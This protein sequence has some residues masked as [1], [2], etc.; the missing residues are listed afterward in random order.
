MQDITP[1]EAPE[2]NPAE[3]IRKVF[4]VSKT[5][6]EEAAKNIDRSSLFGITPDTYA[7][8]KDQ[9]DPEADA[10]ERTPATLEPATAKHLQEGGE[11]VTALWKEDLDKMNLIEKVMRYEKHQLFDIP[12]K[13]RELNE[14]IGKKFDTEDGVLEETEQQHVEQIRNELKQMNQEAE[15]LEK[16]GTINGVT[17]FATD[18][19]SAGGD[20]IRSYWDNIELFGGSVG[21]GTVIGG[22]IGLLA[23]VP[24]GMLVGMSMGAKVGAAG[25][26]AMVGFV[27][28]FKQT[29][30][31]L[32][33]EL[34]T[35]TDESGKPLNLPHQRNK[36]I[37]Y[38]AGVL[39]GLVGGVAGYGL[40]KLNPFMRR[41]T[42]PNLAAKYISKS[43]ALLAKLDVLGSMAKSAL[44]EGGEEAVQEFISTTSGIFGK[45]DE[46]EASFM[47]A[48]DEATNAENLKK[49]AYAG[50][51]GVGVGGGVQGVTA[52]A[53]GLKKRTSDIQ[54]DRDAQNFKEQ[55]EGTPEGQPSYY[56]A[57]G[58][59]VYDDKSFVDK[60]Q[61]SDGFTFVKKKLDDVN[62]VTEEKKRVLNTQ[63]RMLEVAAIMKQTKV[64]ELAPQELSAFNKRIMSL[65]GVDEKLY[66][67]LDDLRTFANSPERGAELRKK[68]DPDGVLTK[69]ASELNTPVEMNRAEVLEILT[70]FPELSDYMRMT[71]EG[72]NPFIIRNEAKEFAAKLAEAETKR[73]EIQ[74]SLKADEPL[75]PEQQA[76]LDEE[77]LAPVKDSKYFNS[78]ESYLGQSTFKAV[79]G[80][81][82]QKTVDELTEAQ[83]KARL[84]LDQTII[85]PVDQRFE[86]YEKAQFRSDTQEEIELE[87]Q[88]YAKENEI[89][90][91]FSHGDNDPHAG[92]IIRKHVELNED[93][94][95]EF[96]K[97]HAKPGFS[98]YAIDP[99]YLTEV[100]KA[101]YQNDQGLFVTQRRNLK[102]RKAFVEGGIHPDEAAALMGLD[103]GDQLLKILAETPTKKQIEQ[104]VKSDPL[105]NEVKKGQI[106]DQLAPTREVARDEAFSKVTNFHLREMEIMAGKDWTTVKRGIIKVMK[107]VPTQKELNAEAK[108]TIG[109]FKIRDLNPNRF[110]AGEKRSIQAAIQT[111]VDGKIEQAFENKGKAAIN[112]ELRR[113]TIKAQEA[114]EKANNFWDRMSQPN[115]QQ[116]LKDAGMSD[117]ME[118]F[119]SAYK[120]SGNI[121]NQKKQDSFNKWVKEQVDN[122][123]WI[124]VMP[125]G[126]D[127]TQGSFKDLSVDQYLEMTDMGKSILHQAKLKN[128]LLKK[129]ADIKELETMETIADD[130]E[131]VTTSSW[132]YDPK[133]AEKIDADH[134]SPIHKWEEGVKTAASTV[135]S[136]KS[137]ILELDDQKINGYF[138]G[139]IGKPLKAAR[140]N[141]RLEISEIVQADKQIIETIY[142]SVDAFKPTLSEYV[143]VPEFSDIAEIGDGQGNVLKSNLLVMLAHFG[144]P[145]GKTALTNF[146][147]RSGVKLTEAQI[148]KVLET[149]L[150]DK[151]AAFVQ[152]FM[153]DRFK[154]FADRSAELHE[155][156]TGI[157]PNMIE[158]VPFVFKGKVYPGGYYPIKRT[159]VSN[160]TKADNFL[161]RVFTKEAS[162]GLP[163]EGHFFAQYRT[164]EMTKQG[165]LKDRTGS[166][167]PVSLKF[168]N[169]FQFTEEA[170]HD[171]HFREFG[172]DTL[173]I[174]RN[175]LNVENMEAVIGP[176]KFANLL[177]SIM[178][179]TSK[180]SER[181][182]VLFQ[183]ENGWINN[184]IAKAH[185]LHAVQAIGFN[186]TS[187]AIQ[188]DSLNTLML[189]MGPKTPMYLAKH[190]ARMG[191]EMDFDSYNHFVKLASEI[192]KDIALEQD[193]VDSTVTKRQYDWM[194]VGNS[195]FKNYKRTGKALQTFRELQKKVV[196]ASFFLPREAD[197]FNKTLATL[198]L[199]E[200]FLAGDIEGYDLK[201]L[202]GMSDKEKAETMQSVIQ[203]AIDTT[204][205][206]SATEDK[207]PLEKQ[208]AAAVFVRYWTDRRTRLNTILAQ[209]EK[210]KGSWKSGDKRKAVNHVMWMMTTM[211][212]SSA[213]IAL[214]RN[215]EESLYKRLAKV[216]DG[217]DLVELGVDKTWGF[218]TAPIDQSLNMIPGVDA[219][220]YQVENDK[221][222]GDYRNVGIPITGVMSNI[223]MGAVV[224]KDML[225]AARKLRLK[226]LNDTNKKT[227]LTNMG[228]L[229]GGAPT[230]QTWALYQAVTSNKVERGFKHLKNELIETHEEIDKYI[231]EF[232]DEEG[233]EEFIEDLKEYKKTLP[234]FDTD[235]KNVI[236]E[237]TKEKMVSALSGGDWK[238]YDPDTTAAGKYQFTEQRWNELM[239]SNPELGLTENGRI[240]KDQSQ[241]ERAINFEI[242]DNTRGFIAYDIEVTVPNL[243]GAHEFGFDTFVDIYQAKDTAK[244]TEVIGEDLA[245]KPAYSAFETIGQLKEYLAKRTGDTYVPRTNNFADDAISEVIETEGGFAN[246][247]A[248]RGGPTKYGVTQKTYNDYMTMK[249]GGKTYKSTVS[250]IRNMPV[251]VARDVYK[252]MYWSEVKGDDIKS[253]RVA[254]ALLDQAIHRGPQ[255]AIRQVQEV[256]G[257][258]AD[259]HMG[260]DTI[261]AINKADEKK[262]LTLF[263]DQTEQAYR[264]IVKNN[265]SQKV[266]AKGWKKRA[267]SLRNKLEQET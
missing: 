58:S 255:A 79:E 46:S 92:D 221:I 59:P 143:N 179:V 62:A 227:L 20:M 83:T 122:G 97:T 188:A 116:E 263:L 153:V 217:D 107:K 254:H 193:G 140:T 43:P 202:E 157:R 145:D 207:T 262:F 250:E 214:V 228:Y 148:Q 90:N 240:A 156:T 126:L 24:G 23:P 141:K 66:F 4:T 233:S 33:N 115:A 9:L 158:A 181:E 95:R 98:A 109:R 187:A 174:L 180:T 120:L 234:Q 197:K 48:L 1:P 87:T 172:I 177:N 130:I 18:V 142:G 209:I 57:D 114:V 175:P 64:K 69:M 129:R 75:T 53:G 56:T 14:Y 147:T 205:T 84:E 150:S 225:K 5:P 55:Q 81:V 258:E 31:S 160:D 21:A 183:E 47:N 170:V 36:N 132:K 226:K 178:D 38:S 264:T 213:F 151:D 161:Q 89:I 29:S 248:D 16:D 200:Q 60:L 198:A 241:Q 51:V 210:A 203:Q 93:V 224:V 35:A 154:R 167:R 211:G 71:P 171:I 118:G 244:L 220:K 204:L 112:N 243:L 44:L 45:M 163:D 133:R 265:P 134:A 169:V 232:K 104:R 164:A 37:S 41:F 139:L 70:E 119:M 13:Q 252:T 30:R 54:A 216:N 117:V 182:G 260:P 49:Y 192:N 6:A 215:D 223:A 259:G 245:R 176:K 94:S 231:E 74:S 184:G 32:Y 63:N 11:Q 251:E 25:G 105:R 194:P 256:L 238:K 88:K 185:S 15:Y 149:H 68:I 10:I 235:V 80:V 17:E 246:H 82:D 91:F 39:S 85:N 50:A 73:N 236:P 222:P 166:Q 52:A 65:I 2:S 96:T 206:S 267:K 152:Q 137:I 159:M 230:N 123:L 111:Y 28:G 7:S 249:N 173:K 138:H 125:E 208:K 257:L 247:R 128:K 76:K 99:K 42:N 237:D 67:H 86:K 106:K 218:L 12:S 168:E 212:M 195:F 190:A 101:I 239:K 127:N 110:A 165:R 103:S 189:R 40:A 8:M 162:L 22:G 253:F 146:Q 261:E 219:I 124:P 113:E 77:I 186:V 121:K 242:Q 229:L 199:A 266:F 72:E 144:D 136:I 102:A 201:R 34:D 108:K 27:D 135:S 19:I 78:R 191:K 3:D 26:S 131:R 155:R 196:D 61:E 100:Q